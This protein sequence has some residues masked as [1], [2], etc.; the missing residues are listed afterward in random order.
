MWSL[1]FRHRVFLSAGSQTSRPDK[2][3]ASNPGGTFHRS[4]FQGEAV[5]SFT[6]AKALGCSVHPLRGKEGFSSIVGLHPPGIG[7]GANRYHFFSF[8]SAKWYGT[9]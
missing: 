3:P 5:I 7:P 8:T 6:Q 1:L 4:P 9:R 2:H